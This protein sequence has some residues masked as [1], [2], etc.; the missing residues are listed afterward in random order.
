MSTNEQAFLNVLCAFLDFGFR[1]WAFCFDPGF[2]TL[3][4]GLLMINKQS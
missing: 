2:K 3:D 1:Y 4:S